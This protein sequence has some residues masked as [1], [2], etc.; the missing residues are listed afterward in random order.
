MTRSKPEK[1]KNSAFLLN[2]TGKSAHTLFK[3]LAYSATPVSV[4]Y[5]DLQLLLLQH[6]KPTKFEALERVKSHSVGRNPNQGIREFVLE[7]L[8]P[9]V[10]CGDLLDMHLKDRLITGNNNIILQNELLKL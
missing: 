2:A 5:E 4:P 8:T 7:L 9:V 1:E 10:K 6:V 3:N